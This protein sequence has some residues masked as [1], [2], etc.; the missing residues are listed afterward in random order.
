[1]LSEYSI[2]VFLKWQGKGSQRSPHKAPLT[3]AAKIFQCFS[4]VLPLFAF[5]VICL[6]LVM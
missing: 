5:I 3:D 6:N 1:M 4:S 2:H